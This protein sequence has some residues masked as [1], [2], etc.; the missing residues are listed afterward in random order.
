[1][2]DRTNWMLFCDVFSVH[3]FYCFLFERYALFVIWLDYLHA[4]FQSKSKFQFRLYA[5]RCRYLTGLS[6]LTWSN[7]LKIIRRS[8]LWP[9]M[10]LR[11]YWFFPMCR[12][13]RYMRRESYIFLSEILHDYNHSNLLHRSIESFN[14]H[15]HPTPS[16]QT[17]RHLTFELRFV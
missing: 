5:D 17:Y 9:N 12:K 4:E 10:T 11:R 14:N 15:P 6:L 13:S 2:H 7:L 3:D 16:G 8:V 1:M